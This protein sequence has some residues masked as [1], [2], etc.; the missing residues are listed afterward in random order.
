MTLADEPSL[1]VSLDQ[2]KD[3][4]FMTLLLAMN[5]TRKRIAILCVLSFLALC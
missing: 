5:D 3:E 1:A 4:A 2:T